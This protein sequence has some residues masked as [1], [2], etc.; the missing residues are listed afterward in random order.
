MAAPCPQW[1]KESFINWL[2]ADTIH[3]L[4]G[5]TEGQGTSYILGSEWLT[6]RGSVGKMTPGCEAKVCDDDGNTLPPN[7][8]AP[9]H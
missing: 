2:G 3:E 8:C 9:A 4:Y 6:K 1:L 7:T 5:A